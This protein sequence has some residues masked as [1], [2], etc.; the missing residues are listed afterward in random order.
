MFKSLYYIKTF[1]YAH[2]ISA[3]TTLYRKILKDSF[4]LQIHLVC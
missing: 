4:F 3:I 2:S 1:F